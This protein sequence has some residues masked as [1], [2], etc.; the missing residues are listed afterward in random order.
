[1]KFKVAVISLLTATMMICG[2]TGY[3]LVQEAEKQTAYQRV[4]AV[5]SMLVTPGYQEL[6]IRPYNTETDTY[7]TI[8]TPESDMKLGAFNELKDLLDDDNYYPFNAHI[9]NEDMKGEYIYGDVN[10]YLKYKDDIIYK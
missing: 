5:A 6:L 4:T 7:E 9:K 3:R 10:L 8:Y 2:Y 1:M